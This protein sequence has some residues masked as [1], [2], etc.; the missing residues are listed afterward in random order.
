LKGKRGAQTTSQGLQSGSQGWQTIGSQGMQAIGSQGSQLARTLAL[1]FT[2]NPPK[3]R[4]GR[5][6]QGSKQGSQGSQTTTSQGW[7][8]IGSQGWQATGSQGLQPFQTTDKRPK[9]PASA[10]VVAAKITIAVNI[11]SRIWRFIL[12]LLNTVG[13]TCWQRLPLIR[14]W[15][16]SEKN[17]PNYIRLRKYP[18][19]TFVPIIG[20]LETGRS[21]FAPTMPHERT[22][23]Y[24]V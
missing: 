5:G 15:G 11:G 13:E 18:K 14:Y 22:G 23:Q 1:A 4:K 20:T 3:G 6:P 9:M 8:A 10:H 24:E 19:I 12:I 17:H 2:N 21:H 7:H 16:L